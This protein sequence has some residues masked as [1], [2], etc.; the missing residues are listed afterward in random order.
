MTIII[1][2]ICIIIILITV[3]VMKEIYVC[4]LF[5]LAPTQVNETEQ[6]APLQTSIMV[7]VT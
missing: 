1:I 7:I 2:I 4:C 3:I 5:S 6:E